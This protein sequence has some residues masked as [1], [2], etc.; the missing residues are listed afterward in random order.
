MNNSSKA[1]YIVS[2]D[3]SLT[4]SY[5]KD[6]APVS[7]GYLVTHVQ[8]VTEAL[9]AFPRLRPA[10]ILF[11]ESAAPAAEPEKRMGRNGFGSGSGL[12]PSVALLAQS[13]PVLL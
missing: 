10:A 3:L 7:W 12:A 1:V 6:L 5:L 8:S 13:A 9:E 4:R 11:D 2:T